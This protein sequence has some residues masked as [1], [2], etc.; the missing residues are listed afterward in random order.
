G[1]VS[2]MPA[3]YSWM[4]PDQLGWFTSAFYPEGFTRRYRALLAHYQVPFKTRFRK[5]SRGQ[6]AKVSLALAAAHSPPLLIMD[7]PTSGLDP[8]VRRQFL[9]SMVDVAAAGRTV[10]LSSHQINE[11]Q[12][13]AD[14]VA[15]LHRGEIRVCATLAD[16]RDSTHEFTC[17]VD[18][19]LVALA[20]LD[21]P[22]DG[23][24]APIQV[25]HQHQ[26]GR[27]HR[28]TLRGQRDDLQ[29]RLLA[30]D[31]VTSV[32]HRQPSL[33]DVFVA[34]TS[35]STQEMGGQA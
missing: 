35:D 11:V 14:R 34:V 8:L 19:P 32:Q 15:I 12:R 23:G 20:R 30:M 29:R 17:T 9:E 4:T 7:E 18:D 26:D 1:Y 13:V 21:A 5:L 22:A 2:D 16:L 3:M 28:F 24:L 31:N 10:L 27:Q 25:L 6:R 33:E